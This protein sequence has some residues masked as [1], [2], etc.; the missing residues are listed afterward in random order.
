MSDSRPIGVFDSGIGG[1]TVLRA[2]AAHLP[3]EDL[4]YL[5]DTARLPYGTKS[6][7]TV[8]AYAVQAASL[9]IQR[10]VKMV[11]IACNTASAVALGPLAAALAPAPVIGVVQP[12]ARAGCAASRNG[13]IAVIGTESTVRG[14][15]YV[16]AIRAIRPD[17]VVSQAACTVFVA[18]AEEGWI[19]GPVLL[20]AAKAYLDPLFAGNAQAP[21]TLLLGCTHF[22]PLAPALGDMLGPKVQLIDSAR[23]TAIAVEGELRA[24]GLLHAGDAPGGASFMVTDSSERFAR[25]GPVFLGAPIAA[26]AVETI[27]L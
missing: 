15:A 23:A 16:R 11:V 14:G 4:L 1:L 27:D 9:L 25:V 26:G 19:D 7:A 20:G 22:P 6:S 5:G 3:F 2:L 12:G 8:A 24:R 18:L 17:A 21:D 13:H 10:G